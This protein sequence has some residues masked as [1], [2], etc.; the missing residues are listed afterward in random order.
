MIVFCTHC[1]NQVDGSA[2]TCRNCGADIVRDERTYDEK[3]IDALDHPLNAA[4]VRACWL[5]GAK[6]IEVAVDKLITVAMDDPDM[7]VRHAAI[8]ALGHLHSTKIAP[9]LKGLLGSDDRW[10]ETDVKRSLY[11]LSHESGIHAQ[12]EDR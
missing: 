4:R 1:W 12:G 11:R 7:F 3:L 10:M 2:T 8:Q 9:F 5:I 6:T